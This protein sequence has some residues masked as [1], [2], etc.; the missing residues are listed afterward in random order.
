MNNK[1]VLPCDVGQVSDGYHTF[2]E[3]YDHRCLLFLALMRSHPLISWYSSRHSDGSEYDGWFIAG[4]QLNDKQV[5]YHLN[6]KYRKLISKTDILC[7]DKAP[8]W[9]GHTSS[10][11][12]A[13]LEEWIAAEVS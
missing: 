3:L 10:D 5:S 6:N 7:L 2:D 12:L 8:E 11:V 4:M 13:R 1:L 9:D